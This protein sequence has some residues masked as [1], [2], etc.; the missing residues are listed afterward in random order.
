MHRDNQLGSLYSKNTETDTN[1]R[2]YSELRL[3]FQSEPLAVRRALES[4]LSGLGHL[5]LNQDDCGTVELVLAEVMNNIV[6]HA[7]AGERSGVIELHI[8]GTSRGL[9]CTVIDDGLPMPD[10][11]PPMGK[12]HDLSCSREDLP[13]GG[14]GWMLIRELADELGYERDGDK[15]KLT[16]LLNVERTI[17]TS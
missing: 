10:G 2:Q 8:S 16:F 3:F 12:Q 11:N 1:P 13:E 14:F 4:I 9:F 15:N 5:D 17:L 6:E 7:Y